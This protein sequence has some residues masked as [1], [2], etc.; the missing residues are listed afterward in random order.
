MYFLFLF[1]FIISR[2]APPAV[3]AKYLRML[4]IALANTDAAPLAD[5]KRTE[6]RVFRLKNGINSSGHLAALRRIGWSVDEYEVGL[7]YCILF[8]L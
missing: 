3:H 8:S 7:Y 4:Q 5:D 6:L 2:A 1:Y